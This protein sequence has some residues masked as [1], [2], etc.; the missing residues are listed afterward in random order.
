MKKLRTKLIIALLLVT[1]I[2][3]MVQLSIYATNENME[4]VKKSDTEYLIYI[5]EVMDTDF[6]FAF[7][8]DKDT[9]PEKLTYIKS[10]K[11]SAE[12]NANSI[13]Y[14]DDTTIALFSNDTY[15]WVKN[16]NKYILEGIKID[17][18]DSITNSELSSVDS[19]SKTIKVDL[20]QLSQN[21]EVINDVVYKTTVGK[22]VL[23]KDGD[24]KYQL[25]KAT[26]SQDYSNFMK[27]AEKISKLNDNSEYYTKLE[28]YANFYDVYQKLKNELSNEAWLAVENNEILQP[29]EANDGEEYILWLCKTD[30]NNLTDVQFLTC[31]KEM[32]QEKVIEKITTK[33]P[34]TYDNNILLVILGILVLATIAVIIR[35][36]IL[37]KSEK[38]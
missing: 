6:S 3:S 11:D 32:S 30:Q 22:V 21:E 26:T 18:S 5:K 12:N 2:F 34:V 7:S 8:N 37:K 17:L 13:A 31:K 1:V 29:E 10:A 14:I 38:K 33:L 15:M 28:T 35:I 36:I 9:E 23:L 20:T 19:I 27:L 4:I 16:S 25:V 24:Y